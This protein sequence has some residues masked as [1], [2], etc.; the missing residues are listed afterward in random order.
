MGRQIL[1]D[2]R[3]LDMFGHPIRARKGQRGRPALQITDQ[4]RD[5]VDAALA[6]GFGNVR[7]CQALD[8]K[9][10][11][12]K[13]HFGAAL[14]KRDSARDRL[15]LAL[16]AA[17]ARA[18]IEDRKPAAAAKLLEMMRRDEMTD[19]ELRLSQDPPKRPA[20]EG[21][22]QQIARLA[23]DVDAELDVELSQEAG[24]RVRH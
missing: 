15:E 23:L 17:M 12:L 20:S 21:K 11:S 6:K 8:I 10:A 3:P 24:L 1:D 19:A 4:D 18:A 13:R 22:K 2:D 14:K 7:I 5:A 16:F 9:L